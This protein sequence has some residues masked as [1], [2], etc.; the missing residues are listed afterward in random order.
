M[1][2]FGHTGLTLSLGIL[3]EHLANKYIADSKT[4]L[5]ENTQFSPSPSEKSTPD[6]R[7]KPL[8]KY[9]DYRLIVLGSLLPDIIDKP[10]GIFILPSVFGNG[11]TIAH[12]FIFNLVLFFSGILLLKIKRNSRVLILSVG[13]AVHLLFDYMWFYP[14]ILFWPLFGFQFPD[15]DPGE[16][17]MR[18]IMSG[19]T[20]PAVYIPEIAGFIIWIILLFRLG[21]LRL[22]KRY[23]IHGH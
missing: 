9:L 2:L 17:L 22:I 7:R 13:S 1:L 3:T 18:M 8:L 4:S 14:G 16:W 21:R 10:L 19:L 6:V 23:F 12:T 11:R 20:N 5:S 15:V